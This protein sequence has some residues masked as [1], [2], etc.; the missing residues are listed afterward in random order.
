MWASKLAHEIPR[1][2][3]ASWPGGA[4]GVSKA[5]EHAPVEAAEYIA[6]EIECTVGEEIGAVN[7]RAIDFAWEKTGAIDISHIICW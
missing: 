6:H 1:L 7:S 4:S 3:V 2:Y 5:I